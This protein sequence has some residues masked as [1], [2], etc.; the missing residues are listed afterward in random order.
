ML[1][2][3]DAYRS[4]VRGSAEHDDGALVVMVVTE[5]AK[6]LDGFVCARTKGVGPKEDSNAQA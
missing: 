2:V 5:F 1:V 3:D 4:A 6:Q